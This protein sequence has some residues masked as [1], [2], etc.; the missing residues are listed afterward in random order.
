MIW[1]ELE[2]IST[3]LIF[4]ATAGGFGFVYRQIR[5]LER[6]IKLDADG[7]L[8]EQSLSIL[9]FIADRPHLYEY[10]YASKRLDEND[11]QRA[12]V[13]CVCEM[14]ANYSDLVVAALPNLKPDV[15][16]R[17]ECFIIDTAANSPSLRE[18]VS[19]YRQWYSD[20]LS[21]LIGGV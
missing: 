13:A 15:R 11:P 12:E 2:A 14:I 3:L 8:S 9:S 7:R 1:S 21:A 18:H 4:L 6:T 19:R 5:I 17:W 10:F 16:K 20:G